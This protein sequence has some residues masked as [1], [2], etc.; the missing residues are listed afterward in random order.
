ML[1]V[2]RIVFTVG[3]FFASTQH[4]LKRSDPGDQVH[5]IH[6]GPRALGLSA[7]FEPPPTVMLSVSSSI[8]PHGL[9]R[10]GRLFRWGGL[11]TRANT[12]PIHICSTHPSYSNVTSVNYRL[13]EQIP[14]VLYY[15]GPKSLTLYDDR[16]ALAVYASSPRDLAVYHHPSSVVVYTAPIN[17]IQFWPDLHSYQVVSSVYSPR[18]VSTPMFKE[19]TYLSRVDFDQWMEELILLGGSSD[20]LSLINPSAHYFTIGQLVRGPEEWATRAMAGLYVLGSLVAL[21]VLLIEKCVELCETFGRYLGQPQ[22]PANSSQ[23]NF[24]KPIQYSSLVSAEP[25]INGDDIWWV[26]DG[27]HAAQLGALTIM[28]AHITSDPTPINAQ[29]HPESR[30]RV[31]GRQRG[32]LHALA[33]LE[34]SRNRGRWDLD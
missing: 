32:F 25:S 7:P 33:N 16:R 4:V 8:H 11:L 28:L 14:T 3:A 6:Q 9:A 24:L 27:E 15:D 2:S 30:A 18:F 12:P 1:F 13:T 22:L 26:V 20:I 19:Y 21:V 10:P 23:A 5:L 34:S 17:Y 29:S 31:V